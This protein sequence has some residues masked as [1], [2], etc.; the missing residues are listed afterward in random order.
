MY[1]ICLQYI[2]IHIC[3]KWTKRSKKTDEYAQIMVYVLRTEVTMTMVYE[4]ARDRNNKVQRTS[5]RYY[6]LLFFFVFDANYPKLVCFVYSQTLLW[7]KISVKVA[8]LCVIYL[9]V[10]R[11]EVEGSLLAFFF[12]RFLGFLPSFF[13][14]EVVIENESIIV[15]D[16][17]IICLG[18]TVELW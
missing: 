11:L 8:C 4:Y 14:P 15:G 6:Y 9:I 12:L 16:R 5:F 7:S 1:N 18:S 3:I 17:W 10:L 13:L 2:M